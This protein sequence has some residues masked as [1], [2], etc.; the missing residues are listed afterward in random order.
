MPRRVALLYTG[1]Q[2]W[3][4]LYMPTSQEWSVCTIQAKSGGFRELGVS[5]DV[6]WGKGK[7]IVKG[8]C[9]NGHGKANI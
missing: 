9:T 6:Y 7:C 8:K 1:Q 5:M 2:E 3:S 4:V